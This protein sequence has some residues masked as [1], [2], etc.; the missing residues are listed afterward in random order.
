M[1]VERRYLV[2]AA[3]GHVLLLALAL[4]VAAKLLEAQLARTTAS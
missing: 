2:I 3:V 4:W 1:V